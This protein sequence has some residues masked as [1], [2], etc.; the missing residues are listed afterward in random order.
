MVRLVVVLAHDVV[1]VLV[2][3][4]DF[5]DGAGVAHR[6]SMLPAAVTATMRVGA[7]VLIVTL[8]ALR[9]PPLAIVIRQHV[10]QIAP[11]RQ[12]LLARA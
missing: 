8:V 1:L 12:I 7:L 4:V 2:M 5:A 10:N 3:L 9:Q 11:R 6:A